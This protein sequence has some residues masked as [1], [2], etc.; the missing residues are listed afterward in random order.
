MVFNFFYSPYIS[1]IFSGSSL[2]ACQSRERL[3]D[4]EGTIASPNFPGPYP[5]N[6]SCTWIITPPQNTNVSLTFTSFNIQSNSKQC[7]GSKCHCDFIQVKELDPPR[8]SAGFSAKYC[9]GNRPP[10]K[11][12]YLMSRVRIRFVSD[13]TGEG[14]GFELNY[15]TLG[16]KAIAAAI[17]TE[18]PT[19][20]G[21]SSN[22]NVSEFS[23]PLST[24]TSKAQV[25]STA[26]ALLHVTPETRIT[27]EFNGAR[28]PLPRTFPV[29]SAGGQSV[30]TTTAHVVIAVEQKEVEEKVPDIIVLGPSVPVVMIFV[31]VV[32]AIAWWNYKFNSEELNRS[33]IH[34][35]SHT[36]KRKVMSACENRV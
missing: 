34:E 32:A 15:K 1:P 11:I 26:G 25:N 22:L 23:I 27:P 7:D 31:L 3:I 30:W 18:R 36:I 4:N 35:F 14:T 6:S 8:N 33:V 28:T 24:F 13:S 20:P 2:T 10:N 5:A 17:T 29:T 19:K 16:A 12:P 9:D 21:S